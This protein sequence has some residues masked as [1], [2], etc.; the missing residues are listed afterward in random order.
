METIKYGK[1]ADPKEK[2]NF[3]D[4]DLCLRQPMEFK[5]DPRVEYE[6]VRDQKA[7]EEQK[8]DADEK[9]KEE[10]MI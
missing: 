3:K 4:L 1:N 2:I 10:E 5:P 7:Y 6:N 8:R 9:A